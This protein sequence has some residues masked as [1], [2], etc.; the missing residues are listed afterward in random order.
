MNFRFL[1]PEPI[2]QQVES[3]LARIAAGE[4]PDGLE[5]L[6]VD[7]KEEPGRR[8]AGGRVEPGAEESEE[9]ARYLA[10]EMACFANT[11]G[12][13]AIILGIADDGTR[14]GTS[15]QA[16]RLRHR[17]YEL[18]GRKLAVS[19]REVDMEGTR[20]LVL[21]TDQAIE[22][23]YFNGKAKWRVNDHCVP[24]DPTAWFAEMGRRAGYDWSAEGSGHTFE[25]VD[26]GAI[27][28][29]R[30]YLATAGLAGD[31]GASRLADASDKDLLRRLNVVDGGGTLTNAGSL[32]FV[33]TPE[34]G[35][36]YIRRETPGGDSLARVRAGGPLLK[37]IA[38]VERAIES[39]NR[40]IHMPSGF[41]HSQMRA[42]PSR[43]L[44]EAVINGAVHRD[45]MSPHATVIEHV[46]DMLTITSPGGF[47]GGVSPANIITHP[48]VPRYR[49][50]SE[51]AASL[52]LAEREGIGVDRMM[53]DMLARGHRDPKIEEIP[54]PYVRVSLVG[55]SPD[56]EML[57]LLSSTVP[58]AILR[59]LDSLLLIT[60]LARTG[61]VDA[62][63]AAPVLQR[64]LIEAE[65]ALERLEEARTDRV[66][67]I[68][69]VQGAPDG[70]PSAYRLSDRAREIL[71]SRTSMLRT[72]EGRKQLISH[73]ARHRGRV[74]STEAADLAG[75]SSTYAASE[76]L[77]ELEQE[78]VLLPSRANRRGRGFHYLPRSGHI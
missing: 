31:E 4:P 61:W 45:W 36:D 8:G 66:S 54:G 6:Q 33:E 71:G 5:G 75:I 65:A 69:T 44:R 7:V 28:V 40:I 70:A 23:I 48:A 59:D 11:P 3:V 38:E 17:I 25:D 26:S 22:M 74:S 56:P 13:G 42:V 78:G 51:A 21:K 63:T 39:A 16:E 50:L 34:I 35:L 20:I 37:Q 27:D 46:G 29:A 67:L 49:S 10:E 12:G 60:H 53:L 43:A 76:V 2:A 9:A 30:K 18:T 14:I 57:T 72:L 68:V 47:V 41:A 58:A 32:L 1:G 62:R 55:G 77:P 73:W 19:I 24:V 52:R 15:L 64:P